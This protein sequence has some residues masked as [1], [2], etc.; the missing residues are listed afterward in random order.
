MSKKKIVSFNIEENEDSKFEMPDEMAESDRAFQDLT[1]TDA[2]THY[3]F[4]NLF[5]MAVLILFS[6]VFFIA[7][8]GNRSVDDNSMTMTL[9]NFMTGHYVQSLED[10][11]NSHIPYP[12]TMKALEQRFSLF[13]GI[14]NKVTDPLFVGEESANNGRNVFDEM[15]GNITDD[16][17]DENRKE[18]VLTTKVTD[19]NGQTATT[20]KKSETEKETTTSA[21]AKKNTSASTTAATEKATTTNNDPP[22]VTIT[23]TEPYQPAV[24]TTPET[25]TT[26]PPPATEPTETESSSAETSAATEVP[27]DSNEQ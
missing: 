25:T 8:S 5:V 1:L 20:T 12:E 21:V 4:I 9:K 19:E 24:T 16:S 22:H 3:D 13:Y 14:G 27:A 6:F 18:N 2:I 23:Q 11:Y 10:K 26:T 7:V 15:S 17:D